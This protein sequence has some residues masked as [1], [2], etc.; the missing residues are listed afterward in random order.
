MSEEQKVN[1]YKPLSPEQ[2]NAINILKDIEFRL[3][4]D[5]AQIFA[6]LIEHDKR[7][8]AIA[9]THFQEG[10]MAAVRSIAKPNGEI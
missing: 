1:G 10:F 2:L 5:T 7:W 8:G 3:L 4:Q 9:K 6:S